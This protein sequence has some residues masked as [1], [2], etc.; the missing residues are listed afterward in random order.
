MPRPPRSPPR[1][2]AQAHA[3]EPLEPR[4]L[5]AAVYTLPAEATTLLQ[6]PQESVVAA[7]FD[8]DGLTD[9]VTASGRTI[10]FL[11][12]RADATFAPP[13]ATT[14]PTEVGAIAAGLMDGNAL[15]D[16][17]AVGRVPAAGGMP[18]GA[19]GLIVRVLYLDPASGAF[20]VGAR[21]R[22]G[23]AAMAATL[24]VVTTGNVSDGWRHEIVLNIGPHVDVRSIRVLDRARLDPVMREQ[25]TDPASAFGG[26]AVGDVLPVERDEVFVTA[27]GRWASTLVVRTALSRYAVESFAGREYSSIAIGDYDGDGRSDVLLAGRTIPSAPGGATSEIVGLR[28]IGDT[29]AAADRLAA[30]LASDVEYSVHGVID[31]NADG[32]PDVV[33]RVA[34]TSAGSGLYSVDYAPTL[35][36]RAADGTYAPYD[37]AQ[38]HGAYTNLGP[39]VRSAVVAAALG[40]QRIPAIAHAGT[41]WSPG[42]TVALATTAE[43][44]PRILD[45]AG[46]YNVLPGGIVGRLLTLSA[47]VRDQDAVRG[48]RVV[49]VEWAYDSDRDGAI[50]ASDRPLGEATSADAA[51]LWTARLMV[52]TSWETGFFTMYVRAT[53]DTGRVGEWLTRPFAVYPEFV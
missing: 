37:T 52:P 9:M 2:H 30:S 16:L 8:G 28:S 45:A 31:F 15:P 43:H 50:T 10:T 3:P 32:R 41:P 18:A 20:A 14:L 25:I 13:V 6:A 42:L 35:L 21:R 26:V 23:D 34:S 48:G 4:A 40:S 33:A 29:L 11:R 22:Y 17:A 12:G 19:V 47:G 1:P 36:V 51:G 5:L 53:D 44:A 38:R 27:V 49:R 7:D 24:P 39:P 46:T